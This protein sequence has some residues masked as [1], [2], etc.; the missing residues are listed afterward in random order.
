M[1]KNDPIIR[2]SGLSKKYLVGHESVPRDR[3]RSLRE[4]VVRHVKTFGRNAMD[5][6]RG[7]QLLHTDEVEE[8]WALKD[9][10]FEV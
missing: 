3:Y 8:F 4:E 5:M 7:R 2:V 10:S 9:V 6:A 1:M